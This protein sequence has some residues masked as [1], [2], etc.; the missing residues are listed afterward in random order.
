[1]TT[2]AFAVYKGDGLAEDRFVLHSFSS[3]QSNQLASASSSFILGDSGSSLL[4]TVLAL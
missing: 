3:L 1:M 4:H 2:V